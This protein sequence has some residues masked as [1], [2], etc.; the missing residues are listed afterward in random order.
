MKRKL[1]ST[2]YLLFFSSILFGQADLVV[3]AASFEPNQ[4]DKG[5]IFLVQATVSNIGNVASG[6]NYMFVY[7]TK[8]L[9][10][11]SEEIISRV[12]IKELAPGQSQTIEFI[13]PISSTLSSGDYYIAFDIDP[14]DYVSETDEDNVFCAGDGTGCTTFRINNSVAWYQ[15]F[16][17]PIIFIHG[18]TSN[19]ETWNAFTD[20]ADDYYGWT[21]GGRLDYCLNPDDNQSS[22]DDFINSFVDVS[23]LNTGD[24]FYLNFDVSANG[25]I[26]VSDDFIPL[27]DDQSNQSA[28]T[29]QGWAVS[30][31][32]SK[33]LSVTGAEKVIL[34]GHSMGGLASREYIQNP[35]N[36][37][38]DGKH[39][40]AK[41]LTIGTPHGGSNFSKGILDGLG[42]IA[43]YDIASEA[44]RDL[45]FP[46]IGFGGQ[47]LFGGFEIFDFSNHNNDINCNL[48]LGDE[49]IGLNEKIT[50]SDISY[51]CILSP[52]DGLVDYDR[53]DI[54]NYLL[55]QPPLAP[56]R[57]DRF[58]ITSGHTK[59]HQEN[60][61]TLVSAIDEPD[62]YELSYPIPLNSLNYGFSTEQAENHPIP[63]PNDEIDWDDYIIEIEE[64]GLLDVD[65]WNIPVNG[66]ALYLLDKDLNVLQE[67]QAEGESNIGFEYQIS[68]GTYYLEL[69]SVP[70]PNSWRFP[71]AYS[72]LFTPVS[73]LAAEFSSNKR[74]GCEPLIV[75]FRDESEGNPSSYSWTF[76]GGS[77]ATSNLPNPMVRYN[78]SGVYPVSLTVSNSVGS[79]SISDNGFITVKSIPD[80][81]FSAV[82]QPD[83]T[84]VFTNQTQFDFEVPEYLWD[85]GDGNT[86]TAVSPNH[87]YQTGGVYIVKLKVTN[88]CGSSETTA[89]VNIQTVSNSN[90][91]IS[92]EFLIFP[93]PAKEEFTVMVKSEYFGEIELFLINGLGQIVKQ[94][95]VNKSA[96]SI[97]FNMNIKGLPSGTYFVK[98]FSQKQNYTKKIIIE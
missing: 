29:K 83:K 80:A 57:A 30:D 37:Q 73:G 49:I 69:G 55:P 59:L 72:V 79:N 88:S 76:P 81:K 9:T 61:S 7:Y 32:I 64:N 36:W 28:I 18:Y 6:A 2:F 11:V 38:L 1:T 31:A 84:V 87:T 35:S 42:W 23:S 89:T 58:V 74:E 85:F 50:P 70:S 4:I 5:D 66:F 67:V 86:S 44:V 22:S 91:H 90:Y 63:P 51:S 10:I 52:N 33:V 43:G 34:V 17:Y 65:I 13:F 62:Y 21:Y 20:V 71:Y 27:N 54:N 41:F 14:F 93:N 25:E 26:N 39:H 82:L 48:Q 96:A 45:R 98:M 19:A 12:S 8:D 95:K 47:Y 46:A 60:H 77:P 97:D 40:V 75:N 53:A 3:S 94:E 15:K 92:T 16:T 56:Q 68:P 78:E 24:Y